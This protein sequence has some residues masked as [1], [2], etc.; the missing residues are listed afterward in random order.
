MVYIRTTE[1]VGLYPSLRI[2]CAI[3]FVP[4]LFIP[5]SQLLDP[6]ALSNDANKSTRMLKWPVLALLMTIMAVSKTYC[7]MFFTSMSIALNKTVES[8][9]RASMN[10]LSTLGGSIAKGLGP[11]LAGCLVGTSLSWIPSTY[12]SVVIFTTIGCT[13]LSVLVSLHRYS[14]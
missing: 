14:N 4:I 5:L 6:T 10:G 7:C 8:S 1:W 11:I 13:G 9:Q 2:G 12:S 3:G